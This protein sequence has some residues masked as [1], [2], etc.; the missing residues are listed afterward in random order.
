MFAGTADLKMGGNLG[1]ANLITW[2]IKRE[3]LFSTWQ[4][5]GMGR[6]TLRWRDL[7]Q[8][9]FFDAET[10][11]GGGLTDQRVKLVALND[12]G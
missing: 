6:E 9:R 3:P 5:K 11:G 4:Q 7:R 1:R 2:A 10:E 8:E 12:P